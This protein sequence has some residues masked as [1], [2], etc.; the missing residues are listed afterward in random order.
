MKK[1]IAIILVLILCLALA[2]CGDAEKNIDLGALR[3][4]MTS[5]LSIDGAMSLKT[6][7]LESLYGIVASDVKQQGC[8]ITMGGT[9]PDEIL[10]IEAVDSDAAKRIE[11]QLQSRLEQVMAQ[12]KNYDAENYALLQK[13]AVKKTGN[14]VTLFIS[15]KYAELQK[16]FDNF[17]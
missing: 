6:E 5:D 3:D 13:C 12:S 17:S 1:I 8:F 14:Y 4:K 11:E 7:R 2:G 15:A 9:F 16:I 10:M